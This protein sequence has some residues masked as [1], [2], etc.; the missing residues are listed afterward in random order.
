MNLRLLGCLLKVSDSYRLGNFLTGRKESA[1]R[2]RQARLFGSIGGG[3]SYSPN[4]LL[5]NKARK[6]RKMRKCEQNQ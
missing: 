3:K 2:E 4:S 1:T 6:Q 5:G